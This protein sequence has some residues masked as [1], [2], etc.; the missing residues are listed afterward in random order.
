MDN[1][2]PKLS[3]LEA[4][5]WS[6]VRRQHSGDP[7]CVP[8]AWFVKRVNT[9]NCA[10]VLGQSLDVDVCAICGNPWPGYGAAVFRPI[11]WSRTPDLNRGGG[12]R[13][14]GRTGDDGRLQSKQQGWQVGRPAFGL[15]VHRQDC[16]A[17][18]FLPTGCGKSEVASYQSKL[19]AIVCNSKFVRKSR[20]RLDRIAEMSTRMLRVV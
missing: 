10:C 5:M 2:E 13:E 16:R 9:T 11:S 18:C 6:H 3:A 7:I 4:G 1:V 20:D 15:P 19:S 14:M 8:P 17:D 12:T